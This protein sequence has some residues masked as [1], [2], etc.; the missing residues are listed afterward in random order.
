MATVQTTDASGQTKSFKLEDVRPYWLYDSNLIATGGADYYYFQDPSGKSTVETNLKQFSTIQIGW[1]FDVTR[2]RLLPRTT[3]TIAD[4]QT[5]FLNSIITYLKE[6]DIEIFSL[7]ALM[8]NAG[9]GITGATTVNAT[10]I[11]TLGLP[12]LSAV[13]KLPFPLTLTGGKTFVFR[14]HYDG[15]GVGTVSGTTN[16]AKIWMV[17][18]G[19]L[20]REVVGA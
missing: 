4:L 2:I 6:G 10:S 17:L 8:I 18:E 15:T 20:R 19:I 9:A 11:P 3:M 16:A 13:I 5:I 7:P 14:L 12:S 1:V